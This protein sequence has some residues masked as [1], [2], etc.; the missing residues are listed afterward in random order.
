ML[1]L[2]GILKSEIEEGQKNAVDAAIDLAVSSESRILKR[3]FPNATDRADYIASLHQ[4]A[5][6]NVQ[7][8]IIRITKTEQTLSRR[9]YN[10]RSLAEGTVNRI[11]NSG[12]AKGDSAAVIAKT[13]RGHIS[14]DTPGGIGYAAKRL[15]RTEINNAY[16]AQ[17]IVQNED[18]P[19]VESVRWNL[20]KSHP[21]TPGDACEMYARQKLFDKLHVPPKPHPNCLCYI[22]PVVVAYEMFEKNLLAGA[23]NGWLQDNVAA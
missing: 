17:S 19:W 13:V 21:G 6:R 23:Y 2:F 12:L 10:S 1:E 3:I 5:E 20:S 16:H 9:V 11:V 14:P 7:S 18:K 22:T 8:M 4:T 15:A